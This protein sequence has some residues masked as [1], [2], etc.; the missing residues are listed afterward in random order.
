MNKVVTRFAPSPT[1]YLHIGGARTALFNWLFARSQGGD[2]LLRI[3]DTDKERNNQD[4]IQPIIDGMAWLGLDHDGAIVFQ[5]DRAARHAKVAEA[6]LAS[7]HAY[8]CYV[9]L[10]E[11]ARQRQEAEKS[12]KTFKFNSPWRDRPTN[13]LCE[14]LP[15]VI[16]MKMPNEGSTIIDDIVQGAVEVPNDTLDDMIIMR[17]NGT[18]TYMLAAVIDDHDMGV[19]HVIRGDDHLNNAFRQLPIYRA[20]GWPEPIYAHLPMI[21]DE[22]GKKLSKRHGAAGLETYR[23]AGYLSDTIFNYLL[24]MGWGHGDHEIFSRAEALSLFD[25]GKVGRAPARIDQKRLDHLNGIYIRDCPT[26]ALRAQL[27]PM[28]DLDGAEICVGD[29][30]VEQ[31]IAMAKERS[32]TIVEMASYINMVLKRPTQAADSVEAIAILM[33]FNEDMWRKP[34]TAENIKALAQELAEKRGV[35]LKHIVAPMRMAIMGA[36]ISLPLFET[37]EIIGG[38]ECQER[39]HFGITGTK[40]VESR[41]RGWVETN[42]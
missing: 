15:F 2:F 42:T 39:I 4:A 41:D 22:N 14:E 5:S 25:L 8:R 10:D 34:V 18:P 28:L 26:G 1:G 3:E 31:L 13:N 24:R 12:R 11:L 32:K 35:K 38:D 17:A 16:R 37:M 27:I 21:L 9:P 19:T 33:D 7:G 40:R 36:S 23:D 29:A 30:G 20:M 6:L